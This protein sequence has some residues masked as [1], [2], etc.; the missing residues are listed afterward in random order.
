MNRAEPIHDGD[1]GGAVTIGFFNCDDTDLASM[2]NPCQT[3]G[4][5]RLRWQKDVEN[6]L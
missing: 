2:L 6:D 5:P 3:I 1:E 4:G